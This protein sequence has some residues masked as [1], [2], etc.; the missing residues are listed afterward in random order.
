MADFA[1]AE[2]VVV[3]AWIP[4][5]LSTVSGALDVISDGLSTRI[6]PDVAPD[7]AKYPFIVF[8]CQDDP[9]DVRGVGTVTVMAETLYLVKVVAPA[10]YPTLG[11]IL[12]ICHTAMT[13]S[14]GASPVIG[15]TVL[16]SVKDRSMSLTETVKGKLL[17]HLGGLYRIQVQG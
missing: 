5:A 16:S 12:A 1:G 11:S 17:R 7:D 10:S 8:Q 3:D 15:G 13:N 2:R 14:T 4:E 9:A 6:Y